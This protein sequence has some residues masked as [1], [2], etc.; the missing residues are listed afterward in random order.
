M[1]TIPRSGIESSIV[2]L[3]L[4]L[5]DEFERQNI[6]YCYWKSSRRIDA[7]L[8]G[9]ADLDL[10]IAR[11]D[12][13]RAERVLLERGCKLFPSVAN[14]DHPAILSFLGYD[15]LSGRI[16]HL[17][18][19]FQLI[20]GER[21]LKNYR[22]PWEETILARA[23]PHPAVPIRVLDPTSEALLLVVRA[24]LELQP[25]DPVTLR[26]WRTTRH[27]F[28]LDRAELATRVD[29]M[30]LRN[31]AAELLSDDLADVLADAIY[32]EQALERQSRLRRRIRKDLAEYRT[33]NAVEARVRSAGRA[34]LWAAGGLNKLFLHMP[35]PWSRRAPGGGCIAAVLGVDGSGKTTVVAAIR[36]WL[37][38][39]VDLI[40]IYF[41]TGAGRPSL[42]LLPFKLMVPLITPLLGT[43]PKGASHGKISGDAPGITYSVLLTVWAAILTVEKRIKLL[44]ARR[45]ANRGL[46]VLADRYPQNEILD[47]NDGPLLPR[48][49]RVPLWL[50]RFE[51][52]AY[53]L[54]RR[55]PPDLV[56]KL[57]VTP[58][59]IAMRESNMDPVVVRQRIEAA[60]RLSF[61]GARVVCVNAD[62]PLAEVIRAVKG[63]IWRLL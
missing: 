37:G 20:V 46:V 25:F 51:E 24:C 7:V 5:L 52:R 47:F 39:E 27:R 32:A 54:A 13:H 34:I 55:L 31:R 1:N 21:L 57:D 17:H 14:R 19:H 49:T 12:Q 44:T 62:R 28:A 18:L 10:L 29:R 33:Y 50:R 4:V 38:A 41:G 43:K 63:E 22:L 36:A 2:H 26:S 8:A 58:E 61:P 59:T 60:Q 3:I 56:I 35:R 6:S 40:P 53:A 11:E 45:G 9:E 23:V 48:L 15:E 30:M 42:L 16:V